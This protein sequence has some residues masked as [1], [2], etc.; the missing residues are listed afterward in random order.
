[1][2]KATV[3]YHASEG[4]AEVTRFDGVRFIDGES[5]EINS[6]DN[7]HLMSKI[8]GHPCFE[9][10]MGEEVPDEPKRK[11]GRPSNAEKAARA[12]AEKAETE[13][14]NDQKQD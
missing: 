1:M 10:E 2:R 8:E 4:D 14:A 13:N 9:V 5:V 12:A 11:L 7:P 6:N 3:T